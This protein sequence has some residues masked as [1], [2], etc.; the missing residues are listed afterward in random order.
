MTKTNL[1]HSSEQ[2]IT[3]KRGGMALCRVLPF[4]PPALARGLR[5]LARSL[6]FG[7]T[8]VGEWLPMAGCTCAVRYL[9][10]AANRDRGQTDTDTRKQTHGH[11]DTQTQRH[12]DTDINTGPWTR[13]HTDTD[14]DNG[15]PLFFCT[16]FG[17]YS[18]RLLVSH[19]S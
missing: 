15:C 17:F 2:S 5:D 14:T 11:T 19:I 8:P 3:P 10:H 1:K 7:R 13:G 18:I 9:C 16:K 4:I 12:T 6:R